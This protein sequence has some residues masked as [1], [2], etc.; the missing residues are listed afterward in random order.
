VAILF[1]SGSPADAGG[2]VISVVAGKVVIKRE[3]SWNQDVVAEL[4][5]AASLMT[6]AARL[7]NLTARFE[8]ERLAQALVE[9]RAA[10]I[11]Q[12]A[13]AA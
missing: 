3:P 11:E 9:A 13:A 8:L 6:Q 2:V 4:A 12:Y 10:E 7:G 5:L 1:V